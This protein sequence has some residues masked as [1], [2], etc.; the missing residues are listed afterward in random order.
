[1]TRK[2]PATPVHPLP[3]TDDTD[4]GPSLPPGTVLTPGT[5]YLFQSGR[6]RSAFLVIDHQHVQAVWNTAKGAID[7][8]ELIS[9]PRSWFQNR[10]SHGGGFDKIW[11]L[12]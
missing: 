11:K 5:L 6:F 12:C 2:V 1:M 8:Q 3:W 7:P 9:E 4:L 10:I